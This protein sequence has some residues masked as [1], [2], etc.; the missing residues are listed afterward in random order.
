MHLKEAVESGG[1]S[2]VTMRE[3]TERERGRESKP[4]L[5]TAFL[6]ALFRVCVAEHIHCRSCLSNDAYSARERGTEET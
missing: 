2:G 5:N 3:K 1:K 6:F 4:A